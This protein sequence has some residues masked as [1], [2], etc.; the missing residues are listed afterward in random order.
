MPTKVSSEH[1]DGKR[2]AAEVTAAEEVEARREGG[3]RKAAGDE[4]GNAAKGGE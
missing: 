2:D 3:E 4:V 1:I